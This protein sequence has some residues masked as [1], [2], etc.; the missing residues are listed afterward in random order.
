LGAI[1]AVFSFLKKDAPRYTP[2]YGTSLAFLCLSLLG[3]CMYLAACVYENRKKDRTPQNLAL[4]ESEKI[5]LGDLG[6][7][8]RYLL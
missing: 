1:I 5:E 2:G 3:C 6:P 4:T 8:Y 7:D